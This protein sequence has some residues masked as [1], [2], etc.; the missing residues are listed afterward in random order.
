[1]NFEDLTRRCLKHGDGFGELGGLL[2]PA[3]L[4]HGHCKIGTQHR[5][6]LVPID[7]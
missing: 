2:E 3:K 6:D 5:L 7:L 4:I 1:M